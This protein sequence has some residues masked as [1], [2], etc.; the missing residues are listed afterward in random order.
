MREVVAADELYRTRA[1]LD[2]FPALRRLHLVDLIPDD[3]VRI[4]VENLIQMLSE[5]LPADDEEEWT[6]LLEGQPA[7]A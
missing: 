1:Q 5:A 4:P 6:V 3:R 7:A 2:A